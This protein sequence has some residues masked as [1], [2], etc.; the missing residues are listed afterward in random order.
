MNVLLSFLINIFRFQLVGS[1][2]GSYSRPYFTKDIPITLKRGKNKIDLLSL[3]V[4][5]QV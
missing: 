5:L 1:V 4:G 2:F 3:T